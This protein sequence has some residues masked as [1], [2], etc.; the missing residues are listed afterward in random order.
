MAQ[1][2]LFPAPAAQAAS[3]A[4]KKPKVLA[5]WA[6]MDGC[7]MTKEY[8]KK[9]GEYYLYKYKVNPDKKQERFNFKRPNVTNYIQPLLDYIVAQAKAKAVDIIDIATA[10][11]RQ[12]IQLDCIGAIRNRNGLSAPV[13]HEIKVALEEIL[14]SQRLKIEVRLDLSILGD[15]PAHPANCFEAMQDNIE[16][17]YDNVSRVI[18]KKRAHESFNS[19]GFLQPL[20]LPR[21]YESEQIQ[22]STVSPII[23]SIIQKAKTCQK[24]GSINEDDKR[25]IFVA[26]C[27]RLESDHPDADIE[28][29]FCDDFVRHIAQFFALKEYKEQITNEK[30]KNFIDRSQFSALNVAYSG[31][32]YH[33][34]VIKL[35]NPDSDSNDGLWTLEHSHVDK[36]DL[37]TKRYPD[38]ELNERLSAAFHPGKP[39]QQNIVFRDLPQPSRL[40]ADRAAARKSGIS[41]ATPEVDISFLW[42]AER[43]VI[44]QIAPDATFVCAYTPD[45]TAYT[46]NADNSIKDTYTEVDLNGRLFLMRQF[47]NEAVRPPIPKLEPTQAHS[48]ANTV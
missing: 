38:L 39:T 1:H 16:T 41:A 9:M 10:S 22:D 40:D 19:D 25:D 48:R 31:N 46:F 27:L 5:F 3:P 12:T 28:I 6:D 35:L 34:R 44:F 43:K 7:I 4:M 18:E 29:L 15:D 20:V 23:A 30:L 42:D 36:Q 21:T 2:G 14:K 37:R 13:L 33:V 11:A 17:V 8:C 24:L 32:L 45:D 47:I 26:Q